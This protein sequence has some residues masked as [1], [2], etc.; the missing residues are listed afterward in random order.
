MHHARS[1]GHRQR[2]R[3]KLGRSLKSM[4]AKLCIAWRIA[5]P[6]FELFANGPIFR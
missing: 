2:T 4:I 6:D 5:A 1:R 3:L